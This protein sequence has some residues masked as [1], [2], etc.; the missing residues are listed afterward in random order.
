MIFLLLA[1]LSFSTSS[2]SLTG[3]FSFFK[4]FNIIIRIA[5]FIFLIVLGI[6]LVTYAEMVSKKTEELLEKMRKKEYTRREEF[7]NEE[8]YEIDN[9]KSELHVIA[10]KI[11]PYKGYS[12][13]YI[14][15]TKY[16]SSA[17]S[18]Y[19]SSSILDKSGIDARESSII[20]VDYKD[21]LHTSN[22]FSHE[23][24]HHLF[25]KEIQASI[26]EELKE[27]RAK[28]SQLNEKFDEL[29][30]S[31]HSQMNEDTRK[32]MDYLSK[33]ISFADREIELLKA[34]RI[35]SSLREYNEEHSI[36]TELLVLLQYFK[37]GKARRDEVK[38]I[39]QEMIRTYTNPAVEP[40][41]K[42]AIRDIFGNFSEKDLIW[43]LTQKLMYAPYNDE[44]TKE[45]ANY[46]ISKLEEK[47]RE[48]IEK[49]KSEIQK[50]VSRVKTILYWI[51]RDLYELK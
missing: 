34:G 50:G 35:P 8:L 7:D 3:L 11:E 23:Y 30:K 37:E 9:E 6:L 28:F 19:A 39:I 24:A 33:T 41:Y 5:P 27:L 44:K 14:P 42:Y 25:W 40:I 1:F 29:S 22:T 47:R 16:S 10:K 43:D 32:M 12:G 21:E 20:V 38:T 18:Y 26:S 15:P 17:I 36:I 51:E 31:L 4:D 2:T 46:L 49:A 45:I 48:I 13:L